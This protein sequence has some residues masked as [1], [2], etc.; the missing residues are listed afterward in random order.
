MCFVV[1]HKY[2][3]SQGNI[4]YHRYLFSLMFSAL[5]NFF[6]NVFSRY[7]NPEKWE[8]QISKNPSL[9]QFKQG[10]DLQRWVS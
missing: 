8:K 6:H 1:S 3:N 4:S 9:L 10:P 5:R 7:K 2:V